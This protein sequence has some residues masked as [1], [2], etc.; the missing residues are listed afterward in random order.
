MLIANKVMGFNKKKM[1][2]SIFIAKPPIKSICE[3]I[4][5]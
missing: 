1:A 4:F 5:D 3:Q 2:N